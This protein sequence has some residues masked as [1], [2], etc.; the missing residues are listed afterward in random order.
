MIPSAC[1]VHIDWN[2]F[3]HNLRLLMS[4]GKALMPVIKADAY[5]HGVLPASDILAELGIEWAAI[6]TL[7]EGRLVRE[8]GY[9]GNI[10][11]LLSFTLSPEDVRLAREKHIIPL[12]HD[13]AGLKA[14]DT[15]LRAEKTERFD[16]ALK[17]DTG[18]ARLGFLAEEME[19]VAAFL[20][21]NEA[22]RPILLLSHL[23]VADEPENDS[24]TA[25]QAE[26]FFKAAD[27]LRR[28]Y[29]DMLCSLGNSAGLV[30][31][32]ALSGDICRPGLAVYGYNPLFGTSRA[33][34][35]EGLLPVMS[36]S[37][38][39]ISV[40]PLRKGES[41]GYGLAYT[42]ESDRLV[43]WAAIGYSDGYRRNPAPG[44]CMC[45]NGIRVPVIGRVAMQTT[46]LDLTDL[47]F[48]PQSGDTVYVMGGPGNAVTA[49]DLAEWW[50]S[51]PYEVLC[52]LGKNT[53][54]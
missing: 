4:K 26:R 42:A 25:L 32:T 53:R 38:P 43:G 27:I 39:L 17:V 52:L 36:V 16:I 45:V 23:A 48:K 21:T 8:H 5:G 2:N 29:P 34:S 9:G 22:L 20:S 7:E 24:F 19:D 18:M 14:V 3:R 35:G 30:S 51:I 6:G 41:L 40:H 46:C 49:Q 10:V 47:P 37:V 50:G 15:A 12:I 1:H 11:S 44:T 28:Q 33:G 13:W 54:D 31:H